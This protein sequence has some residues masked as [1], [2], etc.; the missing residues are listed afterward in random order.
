MFYNLNNEWITADIKQEFA[1]FLQ[2]NIEKANR[3]YYDP[4]KPTNFFVDIKQSEFSGRILYIAGGLLFCS[5]G[6]FQI[7][8]NK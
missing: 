6:I 7:I 3:L 1:S 2:H 5:V 4:E 8:A